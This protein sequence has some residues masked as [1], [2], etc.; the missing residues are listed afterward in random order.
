METIEC[1]S[2]CLTFKCSD[3]LSRLLL[4]AGEIIESEVSFPAWGRCVGQN[5]EKSKR[6]FAFGMKA[7]E[8]ASLLP[9][10]FSNFGHSK[11]VFKGDGDG[12]AFPD[13]VHERGPETDDATSAFVP[14]ARVHNTG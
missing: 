12:R 9:L 2:T 3:R 4:C 11:R 8:I 6:S 1:V 10:E 7:M 14:N 13:I 5:P